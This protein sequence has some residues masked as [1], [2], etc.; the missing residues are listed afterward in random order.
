MEVAQHELMFLWVR[1]LSYS[2]IIRDRRTFQSKVAGHNEYFSLEC[3]G[4]WESLDVEC[5]SFPCQENFSICNLFNWI[6]V[7]S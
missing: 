2:M 5:S 7:A 3:P 1:I 4:D 6:K